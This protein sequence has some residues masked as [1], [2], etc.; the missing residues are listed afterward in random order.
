MKKICYITT[1]ALTIR[2]FFIPQLKYLSEKGYEVSVICSPDDSLQSELGANIKYFPIKIERGVSLSTLIGSIKELKKVFKR[3]HFDIV[4]YSTP[5]AAFC[6]SVA[7]SLSGV[8]IRNYHLM[9]LRYLGFKGAIKQVFKLLEKAT[10]AMSTHIECITQ[11]NLD[12]C[13]NDKLFK[14]EKAVIVWNGSTGGVDL[15]RFDANKRGVWRTQIRNKLSID[16]SEFVFGFVGR[17]TRDKGINEILS[18]YRSL[19]NISRLIIVGDD[20]GVN[21]LDKDLWEYAVKSDNIIILESVNNIE[22]Y[23]AAIDVLLLPS[24]REGFGMVIAEAAAMGTPAIVSDI[25]GPIDV[26]KEGVTAVKVGVK[27]SKALL[28]AMLTFTNDKDKSKKMSNACVEWVSERFNS[29][30][31]CEKIYERKEQVIKEQK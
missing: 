21:T 11:S 19:E 3:E 13:V 24:Y 29:N 12:M 6:A 18:A 14:R 1:I 9:G 28:D 10:C 25:P 22:K 23:Y 31:L 17:I 15:T 26:I 2:S 27:N 7:A 8:R 20:E 4:Q 5:N 16:E 30:V